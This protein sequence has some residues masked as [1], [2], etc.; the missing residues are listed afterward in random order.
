VIAEGIEREHQAAILG[1][2]GVQL[3]Q[4]HL[5]SEP[6]SA[7]ELKRYYAQSR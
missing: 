4:G 6:L 5:F 1:A 7:D 3:A 2:A